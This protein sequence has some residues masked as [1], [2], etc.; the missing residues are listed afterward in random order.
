MKALPQLILNFG[1]LFALF[2]LVQGCAHTHL[3][4]NGMISSEVR[5]S[6][7]LSRFEAIA[8]LSGSDLIARPNPDT[9]KPKLVQTFTPA[10]GLSFGVNREIEAGVRF[11]Y[12]GP[13]M[14]LF[15]YQFAGIP[16]SERGLNLPYPSWFSSDRFSAAFALRPGILL[17]SD[18]GE[19]FTYLLSDLSVVGGYRVNPLH[20][21][22]LA[23]FVTAASLSGVSSSAALGTGSGGSASGT[24]RQ[25]G[26]RVGYQYTVQALMIRGEIAYLKGSFGESDIG[27]FSY[28]SPRVGLMLTFFAD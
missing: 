5:G 10:L 20:L 14:G 17:G 18:S 7:G 8:L 11:H 4:D 15:K 1:S 25:Y 9:P 12:R 24:A 6:A 22:T 3:P 23:P 16:R 13:L 27:G 2:F 19:S 21:V 26:F 28:L